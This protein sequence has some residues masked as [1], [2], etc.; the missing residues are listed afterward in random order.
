MSYRT[1]TIKLLRPTGAKKRLMDDAMD[2][3]AQ[4]FEALLRA[5]RPLCRPG[6]AAKDL[7]PRSVLPVV[8]AFGCQPFKDALQQEVQGVLRSYLARIQKGYR[9][10]YPLTRTD[11]EDLRR[12]FSNSGNFSCS[13]IYTNLQKYDT[14]RPV[15]FCRYAAGRDFSLLKSENS[16]RYYCKLYLLNRQNAIEAPASDDYLQD[17]ITGQMLRDR[18][19]RRRYLLL[20]LDAGK[21]Q[22]QHL[23][24]VERGVALPKNAV[25]RRRGKE[26]DLCVRLEYRDPAPCAPACTLGVARSG[27]GVCLCIHGGGQDRFQQMERPPGPQGLPVLANR[28]CTLADRLSAQIVAADLSRWTDGAAGASMPA[29]EYQKLMALLGQRAVRAGL[30]PVVAVSPQ[31]IGQRCPACGVLRRLPA[32]V[33]GLILCVS[34]GHVQPKQQLGAANLAR[35][36]ERYGRTQLRVRESHGAGKV[37]FDCPAL[38][39]H[40]ETEEGPQA[41]QWF[42]QQVMQ[43]LEQPE[44]PLTSRQKSILHKLAQPPPAGGWFRFE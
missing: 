19:G 27:S 9:A 36:L 22:K 26:Y 13:E 35:A 43:R 18:H 37:C 31:G 38:A 25:L 29:H 39:L 5:C 7:C 8:D 12:I 32:G 34:C 16:K 4:A 11:E 40:L 42:V 10:H 30:P 17:I 24:E 44:T 6:A 15:S 14:L 41:R 23:Q 20:P 28:I 1:I 21:W 3:Y 2:R 33:G